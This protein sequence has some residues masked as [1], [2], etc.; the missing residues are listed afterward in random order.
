MS[1]RRSSSS[2]EKDMW[3]FLY[4]QYNFIRFIERKFIEGDKRNQFPPLLPHITNTDLS[5]DLIADAK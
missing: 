3:R 1:N 5:S 2:F 4:V